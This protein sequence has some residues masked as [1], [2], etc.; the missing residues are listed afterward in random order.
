MIIWITAYTGDNILTVIPLR[1]QA[2]RITE[3]VT[4][5]GELDYQR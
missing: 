4:W 5:L 3:L 2:R 1:Q